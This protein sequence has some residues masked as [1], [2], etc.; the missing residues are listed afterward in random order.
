MQQVADRQRA[1]G[2]TTALGGWMLLVAL[3]GLFA[4]T[5]VAGA[6]PGAGQLDPSFGG[7]GLVRTQP[8]GHNGVVN[9]VTIGRKHKIVVAGSSSDG[10]GVVRYKPHGQLDPSFAGDGMKT[11]RFPTGEAIARGV[12]IG[13]KGVVV[14]A[15]STCRDDRT[16]CDFAIAKYTPKGRLDRSFGEHGRVE[17]SFGRPYNEASSVAFDHQG[18]V[19]VAGSTCRTR[20]TGCAFALAKLDSWGNL[21]HQ[22]GHAGML[23][24][25]FEGSATARANSMEIELGGNIVV[26][27]SGD[28]GSV[29]LARYRR[30]GSP[31]PFFG[32][33]GKVAQKLDHLQGVHGIA[34]VGN[35]RIVA[36]G[37]NRHKR[38]KW[39]LARLGNRG[40]LDSTFGRD[41]EVV[42]GMGKHRI[43]A[44]GVAV[45]REDRIVVT[46]GSKFAVA[47]YQPN[48]N[49]NQSFGHNG[50]VWHDFGFG[51]AF[52]VAIDDGQRPVV[53]GFAKRRFAV[54]RFLG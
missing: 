45:D 7:N 23:V 52:G 16:A 15:G 5:S 6:K 8:D 34:V 42:T 38:S 30:D 35:N 14:A 46:G 53:G 13:K 41:G 32:N 1:R 43:T 17:L 44:D 39:A 9:S 29:L 37:D 51:S 19:V 48:G 10:F 24:T 28:H 3:A 2:G 50:K 22:F 12:D 40:K 11:T 20:F 4:F 31:D 33:D 18:R 27:G 26:G 25:R 21:H 54:S 47:R 49:L 36:V